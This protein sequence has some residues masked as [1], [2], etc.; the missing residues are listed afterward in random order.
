MSHLK[1]NKMLILILAFEIVKVNLE[2]G[3]KSIEN[4]NI[5]KLLQ[6]TGSTRT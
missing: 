4:I 2:I 5:D 3:K 1:E 6:T